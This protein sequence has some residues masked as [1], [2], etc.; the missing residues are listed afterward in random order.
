VDETEHHR[1]QQ[2]CSNDRK[3]VVQAPLEKTTEED[4]LGY[5]RSHAGS[6][7]RKHDRGRTVMGDAREIAADRGRMA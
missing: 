1:H 6:E 7:A 2:A 4:L 3:A 5:W